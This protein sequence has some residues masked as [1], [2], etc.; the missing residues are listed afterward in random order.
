[1][2]TTTTDEAR[3]RDNHACTP[4]DAF[5]PF[6]DTPPDNRPIL[7]LRA[8]LVGSLCGT[9]VNA[10]NIYLDLKAGWTTAANIFGSVIGFVVLQRWSASEYSST[11]GFGPHENNIVQTAATAAGGLSGVFVSA[12]PAMYQ[13]RLL[14]TPAQDYWQL[15]VLTGVGGLFGLFAIAPLRNFFLVQIARELDLRFPSST[16]TAITIRSMHQAAEGASKARRKLRVM[17]YAKG[18]LWDWH[19]FTWMVSSGV[20]VDWAVSLESWEWFI[21]WTPA[22]I[23][24]GMLVSVNVAVSFLAGSIVAWGVIGPY[25]V[26]RGLAFGEHRS[27]EEPWADL[28]NYSSLSSELATADHPSPRHWLLWPGVVCM[29]ATAITELLCQ[30]RVIWI[31]IRDASNLLVSWS[32]RK[33]ESGYRYSGLEE[34][35]KADASPSNSLKWW[36]WLPGLLVTIGLAWPVLKAQFGMPLAETLLALFLA[37]AMSLLAIQ[38]SGATVSQL[39]LGTV[40]QQP[41]IATSQRLNLI[42]GSLT[43]IGASQATDLMGDF[44]VGYLL[45]TPSTPQYITQILGTLL[46]AFLSP[47]IFLVFATA[48]PCILTTESSTPLAEPCEFSLPAA[49]AWRAIAVAATEPVLPIPHSSLLFSAAFGI[50]G[51]LMVL[52]RHSLWT[53]SWAR[54]RAYHPNLMILALAFTLPAVQ[55]SLAMLLGAVV[56]VVWRRKSPAGFEEYGAALAAGLMAGE[57]I[58]GSVNAVLAIL[59]LGGERWGV[60]VGCPAGRC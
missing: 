17:G 2:E 44:R 20:A 50:F 37:F 31:V 16:A 48:Y 39:L 34:E 36:M 53:G 5:L 29:T 35:E 14:R 60:G 1:M 59:G 40:N 46:A 10:S 57:G 6:T 18:V 52:I 38:A 47:I 28:M 8:I 24:S 13:L 49:S 56:G 12:I 45:G 9:L 55:Y 51:I 42:G 25:L 41:T 3:D 43:N 33:W 23:G 21:E 54:M 7:T 58:G 11:D 26:S 4:P 30:W 32:K 15:T 22:F 19:P 27:Q